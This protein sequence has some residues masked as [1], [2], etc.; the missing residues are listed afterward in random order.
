MV[1]PLQSLYHT[2]AKTTRISH[3]LKL[4]LGF[5]VFAVC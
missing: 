4:Y 3:V 2:T 5:A 1:L